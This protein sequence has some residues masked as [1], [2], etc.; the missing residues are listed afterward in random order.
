MLLRAL[1]RAPLAEVSRLVGR[2]ADARVP[3]PLRAPLYRAFAAAVGADLRECPA[4]LS[5]FPTFD[6]FFTRRLPAGARRWPS[7]PATA[8]S[9]VDGVVGRFGVVERGAALQAKDRAYAVADLLGSAAAGARFRGGAYLTLYLAPRHYHRVH[10][11]VGGRIAAT[12]HL[13]GRLLPVNPPSVATVHRLFATNERTVCL[14]ETDVGAAA[15]V[16]VGATNVG[17]IAVPAVPGW[18]PAQ[19]VDV[20]RVHHPLIPIDRGD[21]LMVFHLGSTVIVL[22]EGRRLIGGLRRGAEIRLGDPI[23]EPA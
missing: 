9:P 17:R 15:V 3:P 19:A 2:A 7:A 4:P 22:F 5:E 12:T 6:A 16:A 11:P 13:S 23:A 14:L 18:D 10:A 1:A 21:E 20:E 8:G